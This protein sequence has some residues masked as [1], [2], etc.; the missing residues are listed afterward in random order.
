M[1]QIYYIQRKAQRDLFEC[2]QNTCNIKC[3]WYGI[4]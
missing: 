1:N 4:L 3:S 2:I